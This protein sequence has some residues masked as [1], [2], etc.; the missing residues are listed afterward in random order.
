MEIRHDS[1]RNDLVR[2]YCIADNLENLHD[3]DPV[4]Q[5]AQDQE[6]LGADGKDRLGKPRELG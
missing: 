2:S 5:K 3:R 1:R 6:G 4:Y